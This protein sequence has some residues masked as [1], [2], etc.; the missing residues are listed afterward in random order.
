MLY[1]Y[2]IHQYLPTGEKGEKEKETKF[3]MLF[4]YAKEVP[5]IYGSEQKIHD[6][7]QGTAIK[8]LT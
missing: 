1:P 6:S 2:N 7:H 8:E 4:P 3:L 5:A